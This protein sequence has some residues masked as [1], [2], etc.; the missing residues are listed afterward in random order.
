MRNF[1][2]F[3]TGIVLVMAGM[4]LAS[5]SGSIADQVAGKW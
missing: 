1:N 4:L 3:K 5:C 2:D